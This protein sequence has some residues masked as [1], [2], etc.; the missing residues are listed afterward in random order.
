MSDFLDFLNTAD[1]D[2]LTKI[3]G[4]TRS[5]AEDLIAARPFEFVEDCLK[6]RGMG[7]QLLARVQSAFEAGKNDSENHALVPV[8]EEAAP[9]PIE[10]SRPVQEFARE[11]NPPFLSRLGQVL[12]AFI[13]A[14]LRLI[15]M[16]L[17]IG[18]ISA[19]LYFGLP[20]LNRTFIAPVE[21]NAARI[22]ELEDKIAA[23][24]TQ[25]NE[26]EARAGEL[27]ARLGAIETTI[28]AHTVS[29][30]KLEAMQVALEQETE[31]Q[32]NSVMIVLRREIILTRAIETLARAR[33]Y[34][35]QSNFGLAKDDVQSARSILAEL[36]VDAPPYQVDAL[37][38]II[39]RLDFALSNLPAF[40]VIAVDDVDIAWQLLMMGLPESEADVVATFTPLPLPTLPSTPEAIP[41][42]TPLPLPTLPSTPEAIPTV[43]PTPEQPPTIAPT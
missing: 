31:A 17:V 23:L 18:G 39:V 24:Q 2:T 22:N 1:I 12:L 25:L 11:A 5:L 32:T 10:K 21:R 27:D 34:L 7:K 42:F 37:N 13:R 36:S 20:Y 33:L 16:A 14:L 29:I 43:T 26:M 35:S 3:P 6:V 19:A 8:E 4:I 30:A 9:A 15:L 28:E 40:P 41:T 38:Q